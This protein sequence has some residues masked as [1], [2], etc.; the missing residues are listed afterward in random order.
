MNDD[1]IY[2]QA[3]IDAVTSWL[4]KALNPLNRSKYNEGEVA[5]YETSLS[6]LKKIP[7]AERRGRWTIEAVH[8]YELAYGTTA[9]EP[10]YKCSCCGL[11]TES[12]LRL[13]EPIMPDDADFP[14]WC[15]NCGARM[16][17]EE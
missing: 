12:Y 17:V 10:V 5:A 8:Q 7:S 1:T 16:E 3:A 15:G 4:H 11:L 13:D 9:Y 6:E 2:R 14:K